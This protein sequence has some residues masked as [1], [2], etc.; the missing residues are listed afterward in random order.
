MFLIRIQEKSEN[1]SFLRVTIL[2]PPY[3]CEFGHRAAISTFQRN[4]NEISTF[5]ETDG[6]GITGPRRARG[7]GGTT[8]STGENNGVIKRMAKRP[9]EVTVVFKFAVHFIEC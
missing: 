2:I 7:V 1:N 3:L 9:K 6:D 5:T 8:E 4:F